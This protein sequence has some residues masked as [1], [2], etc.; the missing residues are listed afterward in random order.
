MQGFLWELLLCHPRHF[1]GCTHMTGQIVS[2]VPPPTAQ[3]FPGS[4]ANPAQNNSPSP[5]P[6][7]PLHRNGSNNTYNPSVPL[8]Y[9]PGAYPPP[10]LANK[11]VVAAEPQVSPAPLGG[12]ITPPG[13]G[14]KHRRYHGDCEGK[15][16]PSEQAN[17][18]RRTRSEMFDILADPP[19]RR[20]TNLPHRSQNHNGPAY[21]VD[22]HG[23]KISIPPN[24]GSGH[25]SSAH[26]H[27]QTCHV[28]FTTDDSGGF[29]VE[30]IH[31]CGSCG[32]KF[33]IASGSVVMA[34]GNDG[35]GTSGRRSCDQCLAKEVAD[36]QAKHNLQLRPAEEEKL[37]EAEKE[38]MR[39]EI[40]AEIE[41]EYAV[42]HKTKKALKLQAEETA[43]KEAVLRLANEEIE[44]KR[45]HKEVEI[46]LERRRLEQVRI[47]EERKQMEIE[48]IQMLKEAEIEHERK[49]KEDELKAIEAFKQLE[50]DKEVERRMKNEDE[51]AKKEREEK[52]RQEEEERRKVEVRNKLRER[53]KRDLME[54]DARKIEAACIASQ[55]A[56]LKELEVQRLKNAQEKFDIEAE[57]DA[58][59]LKVRR[60]LEAEG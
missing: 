24:Y 42:K 55:A 10:P 23:N 52:T 21:Y 39:K 13:G 5:P 30:L 12:P 7:L 8:Q 46:E 41:R 29:A 4:F 50:L 56:K 38:L 45:I 37:R 2:P 36:E 14:G 33:R 3:P 49:K 43:K 60:E 11:H 28:E 57:R 34:T 20:S 18:G 27:R 47:E 51:G 48:R 26:R 59:R 31:G 9:V 54:E 44:R 58:L 15:H 6:P 16:S 32:K 53:I 40:R 19:L 17:N 25:D 1:Q 22:E 35:S